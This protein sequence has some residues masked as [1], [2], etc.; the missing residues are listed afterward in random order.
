MRP[1]LGSRRMSVG[2]VAT[3][4]RSTSRSQSPRLEHREHDHQLDRSDRELEVRLHLCLAGR[5]SALDVRRAMP[6]Q[7]PDAE[8][9]GCNSK[10]NDDRPTDLDGVEEVHAQYSRFPGWVD[11]D[12]RLSGIRRKRTR[13]PMHGTRGG[14]PRSTIM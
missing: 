4:N 2:G 11:L 6:G 12:E 14:W 13:R 10:G 7:F 1:I 3:A 8:Q 5:F 9:E